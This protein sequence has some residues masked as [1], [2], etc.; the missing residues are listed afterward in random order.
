MRMMIRM[1]VARLVSRFIF[2]SGKTSRSRSTRNGVCTKP[3]RKI[4]VYIN[5]NMLAS[6]TV[7]RLGNRTQCGSEIGPTHR[8]GNVNRK[9]RLSSRRG[10]RDENAR[11]CYDLGGCAVLD[12]QCNIFC[13]KYVLI[14]DEIVCLL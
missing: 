7:N 12:T 1:L 8:S 3:A 11:S 10:Y 6:P 4:R 13:T 9:S 2:H 5:H 14:V